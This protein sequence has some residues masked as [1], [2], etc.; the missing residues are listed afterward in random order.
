MHDALTVPFDVGPDRLGPMTWGQRKIFNEHIAYPDD[1]Y[2]PF[3]RLEVPAPAGTSLDAVRTALG[4]LLVTHESLRTVYPTDSEQRVL[5]CGQLR[6]AMVEA[7][8]DPAT[9]AAELLLTFCTKRFDFTRELPV[10]AGIVTRGGVLA[11]I[12][13]VFS[14]MAVDGIGNLIIADQ[15]RMLLGSRAQEP[16]RAR[17]PLELAADQQ[18]ATMARRGA[19]ALRYWQSAY[20]R[21]PQAMLAVP[22]PAQPGS[23]YCESRMTSRAVAAALDAIAD[24]TRTSRSTVLLAA[25]SA[26][27]GMQSGL[28]RCAITSIS[29]NR[30]GDRLAE[31]VGTLAQD[32][33]V[34]I[35]L[36]VES[37]DD[38]VRRTWAAALQGYANGLVA[39]D[40]QRRVREAVEHE[41]GIRF[42][43]DFVYSD[44]SWN[45]PDAR[46]AA[47]AGAR[48]ETEVTVHDAAYM[49]VR[50]YFTAYRLADVAE[51]SF[52][53]DERYL[54][55]SGVV[56]FLRGLERLLAA[57]ATGQVERPRF[58][59]VAGVRSEPIPT[60]WVRVGPSWVDLDEAQAL[61]DLAAGPGT[62]RVFTESVDGGTGEVAVIAY[63][64]A[65]GQL[66]ALV[67]VHAACVKWISE[68]EAAATASSYVLCAGVPDDPGDPAAW[69]A[70]GVLDIGT[71]RSPHA[72]AAE[73]A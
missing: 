23:G 69:V 3:L 54:P 5:G 11:T 68:F 34:V 7:G 8:D 30:S 27:L 25:V 73:G 57:A 37:F 4:R 71:G 9:A 15:L 44:M 63:L 32:A 16:R 1:E 28:D 24:R 42:A 33:I 20:R 58:G 66:R 64:A 43:R 55:R 50:G 41:R 17:Q 40:A 14:H 38:L 35:D 21:V 46:P 51:L 12:V 52:W 26:L 39:P 70:Q 10:R 61:L 13:A 2:L 60:R 65:G 45:S 31:Y 29:S 53:A 6:V 19:R 49:W 22:N 36:D 59:T 18:S 48:A 47:D 56:T 67:D 62:G 72:E